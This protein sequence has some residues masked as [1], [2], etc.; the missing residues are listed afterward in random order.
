MTRPSLTSEEHH[1]AEQ[2]R[3]IDSLEAQVDRM[4]EEIRHRDQQLEEADRAAAEASEARTRFISKMSHE[5]RSPLNAVLGFAQL[6]A[7]DDITADQ[8]ESVDEIQRAGQHL[9]NLLEAVLD[10]TRIAEGRLNLSMAPVEA[11]AAIREA[12][13]VAQP[14]AEE[15]GITIGLPAKEC[16]I[17]VVADPQRLEQIMAHLLSNALSYNHEGGAVAVKCSTDGDDLR[18]EVCDTGPG[19]PADEIERAFTPFERLGTE[20]TGTVGIATDGTGMGLPLCRALAERM[21]GSI[22]LT[23]TPGKGTTA[24]VRLPMAPRDTSPEIADPAG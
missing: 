10:I 22:T 16:P 7:M 8:R 17:V 13:A 12:A 9:V 11:C 24:T 18:I 1:A 23:S 14:F 4:L 6:L 19:I 3:R 2:A 5:L 15:R 20:S 21:G